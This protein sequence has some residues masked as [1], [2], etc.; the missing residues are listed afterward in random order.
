MARPWR[1]TLLSTRALVLLLLVLCALGYARRRPRV[2]VVQPSKT[3]AGLAPEAP[4]KPQRPGNQP[5]AYKAR[6]VA[7]GDLHGDLEHALRV[8][9]MVGCRTWGL[10]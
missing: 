4:A 5:R 3:D 6:F 10:L 7:V 9:R 2:R 8:L 1:H